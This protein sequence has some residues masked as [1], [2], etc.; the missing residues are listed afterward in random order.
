[1]EPQT[2]KRRLLD[3]GSPVEEEETARQKMR[4]ADVGEDDAIKG[5]NPEDVATPKGF[6]GKSG[7]RSLISPIGY[8]SGRGDLP[9]CRWLYVNGA[10]TRDPEVPHLF[11]RDA[12]GYS[13][14]IWGWH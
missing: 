8:F 14:G 12:E 13:A 5:F 6:L 11:L 4:D 9:M 3:A 1:M 10:D 7:Y 2:K